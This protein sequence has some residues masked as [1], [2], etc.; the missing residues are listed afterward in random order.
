M[1]VICEFYGIQIRLNYNDHN[2]PHFHVKYG[3]YLA[4]V[5]IDELRIMEGQLPP[6]AES[7][8]IDWATIHQ[9]ELLQ[10]WELAREHKGLFRITPLP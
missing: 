4:L 3:E 9:K 7:M 6:R 10:D 2:P 1:P 8:V 5:S